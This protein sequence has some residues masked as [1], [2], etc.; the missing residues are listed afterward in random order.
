M[1][2]VSPEG[3]KAPQTQLSCSWEQLTWLCP[4]QSERALNR[5]QWDL[6]PKSV[7]CFLGF[8]NRLSVETC[9]LMSLH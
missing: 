4:G 5:L 7:R 6:G 3:W 2:S 1:R 9:I 8:M